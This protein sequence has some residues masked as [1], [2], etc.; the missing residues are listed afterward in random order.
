MCCNGA[1]FADVRLRPDDDP[2]RL[3]SLGLALVRSRG[4]ERPKAGTSTAGSS[5]TGPALKFC[6][7]CAALEGCKCRIYADRPRY[8]REFECVLLKSVRA[9]HTQRDAAE[10][11][12][13][14][15]R[16]RADEVLSLLR[17]LGDNEEQLPLATRFRLTSRHVGAQQL[18]EETAELYGRLT[19]AAHSLNVLLAEAFYPGAGAENRFAET[20]KRR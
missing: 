16:R 18:D 12:I 13:R 6:Q 8:C 19:L 3:R 15:A 11:V 10:E 1:I 14:T 5:S 7:P 4:A 20:V 9:G 17:Q 2:E